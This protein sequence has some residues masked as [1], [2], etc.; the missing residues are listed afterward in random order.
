MELSAKE[1]EEKIVE[2]KH[3]LARIQSTTNYVTELRQKIGLYMGW[4]PNENA[5]QA[6]ADSAY[7]IL[8][9]DTEITRCLH[10]HSSMCA[11]E[12][13]RVTCDEPKLKTIIEKLLARIFD[14]MHVRKSLIENG[15]LFGLGIQRKY[16]KK[17]HIRGTPEFP[18][19]SEYEWTCI[20]EINEVDTRRA[21]IERCS[22]FREVVYWTLYSPEIDQYIKILDRNEYPEQPDGDAVQDY[23]WYFHEE[24]ETN[25][26]FRGIGAVLYPIAYSKALVLQY[27][28][29]ICESWARPW[30]VAT[31]DLLKGTISSIINSDDIKT[32]SER[33]QSWLDLM[34][35]ARARHGI[36][37]DKNDKLEVMEHGSTGNNICDQFLKYADDK[38][39]LAILGAELTTGTGGGAGSYALGNV[40]RQQ[41][42]TLIMYS[43]ARL[44]EIL[45]RDVVFDLLYRN[46]WNLYSLGL[47]VPEPGDIEIELYIAEEKQKQAAMQQ[48]IQGYKGDL[49]KI[50]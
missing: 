30:L 3:K 10:L 31:I 15:M 19:I 17:T 35:K 12:K 32:A 13:I 9:Q 1:E 25:P 49:Q 28:R 48:Q 36:V 40:H 34:E 6:A 47:D 24:E 14:F 26:Y 38:I 18:E 23:I 11:G 8:K 20:S 43:R 50:I 21:R 45:L 41:T 37:M 5:D 29:E 39:A 22:E 44:E 4:I 46:R 33:I 42:E 2:I 7:T 27:S 16:Y